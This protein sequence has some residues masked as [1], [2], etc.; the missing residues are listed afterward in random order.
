M[1][2]PAVRKLKCRLSPLATNERPSDAMETFQNIAC[3]VA[4][5]DGTPVRAAH[6]T[7]RRRQGSEQPIDF[8]RFQARVD[9]DGGATGDRGCHGAANVVKRSSAKLPLG[10]LQNLEQDLLD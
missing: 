6:R 2:L 1:A 9:L 8:S 7:R 10:N 4:Q 3:R 5:C